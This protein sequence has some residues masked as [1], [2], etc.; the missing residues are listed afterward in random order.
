MFENKENVT[1]IKID[2]WSIVKIVLIFIGLGLL[3]AIRDVL[4]IIFVAIIL[5]SVIGPAV[6][7]FERKKMPRWLGALIIYLIIFA[8]LAGIGFV[9]G[10][11]IV[12]Q[13][14]LF[15]GTLVEFLGTKFSQMPLESRG[16]F[17]QLLNSW[18]SKSS[19]VGGNIFSLVGTVAGQITSFF[20]ILVV[21]YYLSVEK[22]VV[23]MFVNSLVPAR[24][25][26]FAKN[27]ITSSQREIGAWARA[28]LFL[29][30]T[31]GV[32][33]YFGL[34][35]LKVKYPLTLAVI[36]GLTEI[37][38]WLGPWLGAIPAVIFGFIQSPSLGLLVILLYVIVQ[39]IENSLIVPHVMHKVV[40]LNPLI[41]ILAIL[42]GGSLAGPIG[43]LLSVPIVT[44]IV[45]LIRDYLALKEKK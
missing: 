2:P 13:T 42:V 43:M 26:D 24:Y 33:T 19:L 38:P 31:V 34:L 6:D 23:Q 37:I 35:I 12:Q 14:K 5:A 39:Q 16:E 21:A 25:R 1:I 7:F 10:P 27:F 22:Q 36:A 32:L 40:G 15:I 9:V 41:V 11:T 20:M 18:L 44:V 17:L 29:C 45:I 3:F 28:A 4:L 30:L 8:I